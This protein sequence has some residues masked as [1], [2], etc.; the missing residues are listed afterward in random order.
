M[1]N[2]YVNGAE[3]EIKDNTISFNKLRKFPASKAGVLT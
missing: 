2:A 3:R 1:I